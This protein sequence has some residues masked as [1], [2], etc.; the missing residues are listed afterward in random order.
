MNKNKQ[1]YAQICVCEHV[2]A[3]FDN[4][5]KSDEHNIEECKDA[6]LKLIF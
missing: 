6:Y 3:H 1:V 5:T 2:L 4:N